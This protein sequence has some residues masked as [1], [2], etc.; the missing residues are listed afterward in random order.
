MPSFTPLPS[1]T[2]I[3][4]YT[5]I[6]NYCNWAAY[7]KDV[8]F[9]DGSIVAPGANFT[10]TWRIKN[11]GTCTWKTNYGLVFLKGNNLNGVAN[12]NMPIVVQPG[13]T[14]DISIVLTAPNTAG[15]YRGDW[16]LRNNAGDLFGLGPTAEDP[17]YVEIKVSG[18]TKMAMDFSAQVCN[19]TWRSGAGELPCPGDSGSDKGFVIA[20]DDPQLENGEVY[21]GPGIYVAPQY[22]NNGFIQGHY[23]AYNVRG[24][25][26]FR[27]VINCAY[28]QAGCNAYFRLDYQIGNGPVKTIWR[29]NEAYD[30]EYYSVDTDLSFLEGNS[31]KFIL[32]VLANGSAANDQLIRVQP[33]IEHH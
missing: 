31:V 10:K 32:T 16:L 9:P 8:T 5:A 27:S 23:P 14:V 1:R 25:D 18:A 26:R 2:L 12:V 29:F 13:K 20:V 4:T 21:Y 6:P 19:A 7:I 33:R 15:T 24:G 11:I 22:T 28:M 17:F 30:G 3:P